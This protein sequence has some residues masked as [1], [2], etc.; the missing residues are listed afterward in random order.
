MKKILFSLF[1]L[2]LV[3]FLPAFSQDPPDTTGVQNTSLELNRQDE[4]D[5]EEDN[6][7]NRKHH[8]KKKGKNKITIPADDENII[9]ELD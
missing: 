4:P 9:L 3:G 7:K 6:T 1:I 5:I 2:S 8:K